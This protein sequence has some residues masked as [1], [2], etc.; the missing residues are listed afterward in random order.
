MALN[1]PSSP[2]VNQIYSDSG[3]SWKWNG[4][5]WISNNNTFIGT[6]QS[7]SASTIDCQVSNYFTKEVSSNITFTFSNPP[8]A[9]T[10]YSFILE[11]THT[12]G[13][14]TWPASV[15]WPDGIAPSLST[16]KTHMF[17]F[18]TDDGGTN[19]RGGFLTNY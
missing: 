14:I 15:S 17:V 7:V 12:G 6:V 19:W 3:K 13:T 5:S 2:S 4:T 18:I 11:I 8:A 9:N 1:F 16:P 10:S